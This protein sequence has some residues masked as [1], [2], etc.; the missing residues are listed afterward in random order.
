MGLGV[1]CTGGAEWR[2][3]SRIPFFADGTGL[4][5]TTDSVPY[6]NI[7][8]EYFVLVQ[9]KQDVLPADVDNLPGLHIEI[10]RIL[11]G[12]WMANPTNRPSMQDNYRR[13]SRGQESSFLEQ[14]S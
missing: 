2:S 8:D 4:Q 1:C 6:E 3:S 12:C 5:I 13:L 7:Q 11:R 14:G 9:V 10:R